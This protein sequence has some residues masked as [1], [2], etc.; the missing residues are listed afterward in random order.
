MGS[1]FHGK[2]Q[3]EA[4][5]ENPGKN[6]IFNPPSPY[7]TVFLLGNFL[8]I[9]LCVTDLWSPSKTVTSFMDDPY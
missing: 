5:E 2:N 7:V 4:I 1:S 8:E 3:E 6:Q 9:I